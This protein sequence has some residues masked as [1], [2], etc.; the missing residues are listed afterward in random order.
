MN[1]YGAVILLFLLGEFALDLVA[2]MLNLGTLSQGLPGEFEGVFDPELYRKSQ[3]YTRTRTLFGL[4][5]GTFDLLVLL[6]FW[7]AGG[8]DLMD[9]I[10]R[11]FG[12]NAIL[13]GLIYIG[14]LVL[15]K[16]ALSLPWS[17]YSTFVIEERFGFNK[18][19]PGVFAADLVKGVVL[20]VLIGGPLAAGVLA[21]FEYAGSA[22]WLYCWAASA[23]FMLVLQFVAPTWI[24]PLFNKFTPLGEGELRSAILS[25]A[26][27]VGFSLRDVFVMDGSK[28][29]SKSN[30]F[31]TGF[32]RNKR[33]AL[34]DTLIAKHT[35]GEL[36]SV[37]AHE[38]GH[39]KKKHILKGIA[40][41]LL[42]MAVV[43][44]L[45][46]LFMNNRDL[47]EAFFMRS[48]SVYASL[49]FFSLLYSP[50]DFVLSLAF[51]AI[52]RSHEYEADRF[53]SETTGEPEAMIE[54]LKKLSRDNLSHLTPHRLYVFLK[55][56]H[57]PVLARIRAIRSLVVQK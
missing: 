21:F 13:T 24:M 43:F 50:I 14:V 41:S 28:R 55:Y 48:T 1:I 20:G 16:A 25:Y 18:T 10:V 35:T 30:A 51:H 5:A 40:L 29:S 34:F 26:A 46:S 38:I 36:V 15:L 17:V 8:F 54:A 4:S 53:A 33:I 39:Y 11:G 9:G 12:L 23:V 49:L 37:L 19:T 7:F 32:G 2:N 45:L 3:S 44:F 31:F 27:R 56:S 57:P 6:V 42:Q 22:A 47:S 52:S